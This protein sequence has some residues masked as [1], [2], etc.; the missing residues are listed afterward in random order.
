MRLF[1]LYI[2]FVGVFGVSV[3]LLDAIFPSMEARWLYC[4]QGVSPWFDKTFGPPFCFTPNPWTFALSWFM[5]IL[6]LLGWW[7][8]DSLIELFR[9]TPEKKPK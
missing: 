9:E 3:G 7:M 1:R 5:G 4:G 8:W 6:C 2:G